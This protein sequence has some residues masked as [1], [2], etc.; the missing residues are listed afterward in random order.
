MYVCRTYSHSARTPVRAS[1]PRGRLIR[2]GRLPAPRRRVSTRLRDAYRLAL[3]SGQRSW[4]LAPLSGFTQGA[5]LSAT[6]YAEEFPATPLLV[7][8]LERLAGY[9]GVPAD[10][11]FEVEVEA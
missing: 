6:I 7:A 4:V 2:P 11:V 5:D 1:G 3:A 9:L 10:E 8:R